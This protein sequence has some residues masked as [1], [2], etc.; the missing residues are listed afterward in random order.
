MPRRIR[1]LLRTIRARKERFVREKTV[2]GRI[3]TYLSGWRHRSESR[4][5]RRNPLSSPTSRPNK[6]AILY[7]PD[8]F[9]PFKFAC[10]V[11]GLGGLQ[12]G[13]QATRGPLGL[14]SIAPRT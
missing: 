3:K 12:F 13:G 10:C 5:G 8:T 14:T 7:V 9:Q 1:G 11:T 2:V 6:P 4:S